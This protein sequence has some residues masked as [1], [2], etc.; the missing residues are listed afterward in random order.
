MGKSCLI[1]WGTGKKWNSKE[2]NRKLKKTAKRVSLKRALLAVQPPARLC[3]RNKCK[4][5]SCLE[6]ASGA[7]SPSMS[8]T[9]ALAFCWWL[10]VSWRVMSFRKVALFG[11]PKTLGLLGNVTFLCW[12][13]QA[14][15]KKDN[16]RW[17]LSVAWSKYKQSRCLFWGRGK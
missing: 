14:H 4:A 7:A 3:C 6:E 9:D 17:Q 5:I 8:L 13:K 15:G 16:L 12:P 1:I 10:Y 11:W 2:I